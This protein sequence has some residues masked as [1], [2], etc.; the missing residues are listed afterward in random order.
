[1]DGPEAD[2][3]SRVLALLERRGA[4]CRV[5]EHA[6]TRTI[7]EA[8]A[9]LR[10]DVSRIVKTIAFAARDGRLVLAALRGTRRVDYAGLAGE[11]GLS[12]RDL[13]SLSPAQVQERLGVEPGSVAPLPVWPVRSAAPEGREIAILVDEDVLELAPTA[14]CGSG[15][16][17][18]TLELAPREL[19]RL[20]GGR[21]AR[22]SRPAPEQGG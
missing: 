14:Y 12:R 18:R 2:A 15:R 20:S 21:P 16:P 17:D 4:A 19:L 10:F 9:N 5:H 3:F 13:A 11:L 6:P 7:E 22:F 1:M 8:R